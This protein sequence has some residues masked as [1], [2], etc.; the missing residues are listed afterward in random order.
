MA[1]DSSPIL[2]LLDFADSV[3][4]AKGRVRR[5]I[6]EIGTPRSAAWKRP[7]KGRTRGR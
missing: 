5:A 2:L 6:Q 3:V 7:A 1:A 4:Q